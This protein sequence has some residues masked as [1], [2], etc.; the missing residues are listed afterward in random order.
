MKRLA[1]LFFLLLFCWPAP[2]AAAQESE[3]RTRFFWDI[4]IEAGETVAEAV[5]IGCSVRV[6]GAVGTEVVAIAG[7]VTLSGPVQDEVVV[8]GGD[9]RLLPGAQVGEEI[10]V[11]GGRVLR[12]PAVTVN[13]DI[14]EEAPYFHLPGQRAFHWQGM[15]V[16]VAFNF[17][18]ALLGGLVVRARRRQNLAAALRAHYILTA[19]LG[20]IILIAVG[21]SLS[22]TEKLGPGEDWA[23]MV[24]LFLLF[25]PALACVLAIM[26][27]L[28]A[29]R[30]GRERP[31]AALLAGAA[32]TSLLFL[33]PVVGLLWLLAL[34]AL[35]PGMVAVS[36]LGSNPHWLPNL[37]RRR[38]QEKTL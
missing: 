19:L 17:A 5:C 37:F 16:L 35:G 28:G 20:L 36:G 15:L 12:D 33:L 32:A 23:D 2:T 25:V 7:N 34:F 4:T 30:V 21:T 1:F 13:A 3:D 18:A 22:L 9:V 26:Q 27:L 31:G 38:P 10:V 11:V 29:L 6:E 24:L 8:V 14:I